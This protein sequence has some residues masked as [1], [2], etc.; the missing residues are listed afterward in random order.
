MKKVDVYFLTLATLLLLC[1]VL[2]GIH[3][4]MSKDYQ[5][6]PVHAHL[7]LAG[8]ASLALFG[9]TYRAYPALKGRALTLCHF[10]LSGSGAVL[11][12]P[13]IYLA[14]T[15]KTEKLAIASSL[16][17]LLGVILFLIQVAHLWRT[18]EN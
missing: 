6:V 8:W 11:I 1:G 3:M 13:G 7:N 16:L 4:A 5:L 14:V 18:T 2:L 15:G 17:W 10:I 9:L 12:G